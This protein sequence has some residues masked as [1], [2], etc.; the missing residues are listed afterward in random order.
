MVGVR[1]VFDDHP[2]HIIAYPPTTKPYGR[3]CRMLSRGNLRARAR[4]SN[5]SCTSPILAEFAEGQLLILSADETDWDASGRV[6]DELATMAPAHAAR[7]LP[8]HKGRRPDRLNRLTD[9]ANRAGVPLLAVN[10]DALPRAQPQ[11]RCRTW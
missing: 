4:T 3:L 9:M 6:L 5:A 8:A 1:L 2:L 11:D 7:A 10:D